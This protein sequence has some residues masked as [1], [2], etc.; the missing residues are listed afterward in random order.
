MLVW[1]HLSDQCYVSVVCKAVAFVC[2]FII[3]TNVH[4]VLLNKNIHTKTLV[5]IDFSPLLILLKVTCLT[6]DQF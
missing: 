5:M 3:S 4:L 1:K 2:S 6:L